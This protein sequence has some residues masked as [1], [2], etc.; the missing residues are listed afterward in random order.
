MTQAEQIRRL[1]QQ[2]EKARTAAD[3]AE[4]ERDAALKKLGRAAEAAKKDD[5]KLNDNA[6]Q[7]TYLQKQRR[8]LVTFSNRY[9]LLGT[10]HDA[11]RNHAAE[12][13][14]IINTPKLLKRIT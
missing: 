12:P 3:T 6:R 9:G 5:A 11:M 14:R 7:I 10:G 2:L 1:K 8:T 4:H 13:D